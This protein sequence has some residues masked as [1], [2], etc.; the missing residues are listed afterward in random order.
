MIDHPSNSVTG[1]TEPSAAPPKATRPKF[2]IDKRHLWITTPLLVAFLGLLGTAI[3]SFMQQHSST[4]LERNK[5]EYTLIEKALNAPSRPDAASELLFF[6]KIGL[7]K[8]LDEGEIVKAATG[9]ENVEQLP[10][11]HGAALRDKMIN[12][13]QAKAVLKTLNFYDGP[14]DN[15]FDLN[16]QISLSKF[17]REKN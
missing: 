3:A 12:V 10:V 8:G 13:P 2:E 5:F 7:L 6:K 4:L 14:I 16:F 17:Q 15:N 1:K 9:K 11:F